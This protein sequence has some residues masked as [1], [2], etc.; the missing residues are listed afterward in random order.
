[1]FVY[2][3]SIYFL[4]TNVPTLHILDL[5]L[6]F[7]HGEVSALHWI[8]RR[9]VHSNVLFQFLKKSIFLK[10]TK[11]FYQIEL[12]LFRL[13]PILGTDEREGTRSEWSTHPPKLNPKIE[14]TRN[15]SPS[16]SPSLSLSLV[17]G[18]FVIYLSFLSLLEFL[19]LS[20]S[21]FTY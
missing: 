20:L 21:L 4:K 15:L 12:G 13:G 19:F 10:K 8:Q 9:F 18:P 11:Q 14:C 5:L 3:Y 7:E 16:F 2:S 17:L 6:Q 1:M